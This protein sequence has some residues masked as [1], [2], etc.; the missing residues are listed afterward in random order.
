[1]RADNHGEGGA[2]SLVAL[3]QP[4]TG[5]SRLKL[6]EEPARPRLIRNEPGVGY[7]LISEP[8]TPTE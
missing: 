5:G 1:M 6:E 2:L 3:A 8:R 7:R 4:A